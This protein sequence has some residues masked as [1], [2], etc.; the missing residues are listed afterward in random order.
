MIRTTLLSACLLLTT[1]LF[2][3]RTIEKEVGDFNQLK[4]FDLIEVTLIQSDENR[5][6]I[7]G[8]N[9]DDVRILNQ[10]GKLKLRMELDTRFDGEDT[11]IEVYFKNI[12]II[13]ANEGSRIVANEL[14]E[15]DEIELRAQEGGQIKVG[16][17]VDYAKVK[18]VTGGIIEATG[19]CRKQ[20]ITLT[21]GGIFEGMS[22]K[23]KNTKI[24]ITAAGEAEVNASDLVD[25]KVTAGGDVY[26][27]GNPKEIKEKR[28]AGGRVKVMN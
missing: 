10:N 13:D 2:A 18:A 8:R 19:L 3:Q 20:E 1:V 24:G 22:L 21:T 28:L 15:Q 14:I 27:Y 9:T 16:L 23:T 6:V 7:K 11:Y 26:I 12:D 5:V 17:D 4:V 25:L